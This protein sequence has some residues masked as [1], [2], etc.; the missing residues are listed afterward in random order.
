M[1][2]DL[3]G[4]CSDP[5]LAN[6]LAILK[7]LLELLQL[8]G[9]LI[10]IISLVI[11][12]IKLIVN[13]N[14]KNYN[15]L[16]RNCLLALVVMFMVPTIVNA[17]MLLFDDRFELSSCWNNAEKFEIK[18]KAE[19]VEDLED[20]REKGELIIPPDDFEGG[21]SN[22]SES[23][24]SDSSTSSNS[25]SSNSNS[26][27]NESSNNAE[28]MSTKF[29]N[30][31]DKMSNVVVSEYN[32]GKPWKYSNKNTKN[33]FDKADS[34]TNSTNCALYAVW[35]LIDI[36]ILDSGDRFYKAKA[37]E[38]KYSK[39]AK[40]KMKNK[41]EYISGNGK[42]ARTLINNGTLKAGDIVLWNNA[43]HTNVYAGN[44]KWYDA[45]RQSGINGSGTSDN[46][47]FKTLGPVKI[48]YYMDASVW[49]ILRIK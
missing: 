15:K 32:V 41:M 29:L 12:F 18:D 27:N 49:K 11:I 3:I 36:G 45:G 17:V 28:D 47:K 21:S 39:N 46:Y 7:R 16:I 6:V 35:G 44:N 19:F 34:S 48:S 31:L 23:G 8:F 22:N 43:Q 4:T 10:A 38:I 30:S 26:S 37:N 1:I 20:S 24:T 13:P 14:G 25:S 5:G 40:T 42:S 9:P 33:T 2:L